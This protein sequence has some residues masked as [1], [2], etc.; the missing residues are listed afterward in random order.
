M[1]KFGVLLLSL[2]PSWQGDRGAGLQRAEG[3][4]GDEQYL[5]RW[6]HGHLQVGPPAVSSVFVFLWGG[7]VC[8]PVGDGDRR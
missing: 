6:T 3:L 2:A 4:H 8:E 7:G 5:I 1:M